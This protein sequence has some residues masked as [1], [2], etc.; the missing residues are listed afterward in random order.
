[1]SGKVQWVKALRK[2]QDRISSIHYLLSPAATAKGQFSSRA[3]STLGYIAQVV[4]LPAN[5]KHIGLHAV[6]TCLHM[7]GN[8]LNNKTAFSF[9]CP[10][11]PKFPDLY[12]CLLSA[13]IN[14]SKGSRYSTM[15]SRTWQ[16]STCQFEFTTM[17]ISYLGIGTVGHSALLYTMYHHTQY[18]ALETESLK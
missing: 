4:P 7:C 8:S 12:A 10:G 2:C 5:A 16:C 1:M 3:L 13:A 9:D 14:P 17:T 11:G 6:M 18:F 15:S